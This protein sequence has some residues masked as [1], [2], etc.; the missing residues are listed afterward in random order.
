MRIIAYCHR[1][2]ENCRRKKQLGILTVSE[3]M[4]AENTIARIIQ[5]ESFSQDLDCLRRNQSLKKN[6]KLVTL[7][8]FLDKK[9]LIRVGGRLRH[10][11]PEPTKHS[12][13]LP[14]KHPVT[15]LIFKEHHIK[16]HHCGI[17]QLLTAVR[18]KYW[19][20]SGRNEARKIIRSCLN[21]FRLRPTNASVKMGDLPKERVT[22]YLRPLVV[23]ITRDHCLLERA[24]ASSYIQGLHCFVYL[25]Q[26]KG[27]TLRAGHEPDHRSIYR[28][29]IG[30]RGICSRLF[31][32][33]GT[34]FVGAAR[35]LEELYEFLKASE[36]EKQQGVQ[37]YLTKQKIEWSFIPPIAPNFGGLWES[38]VKSVKRHFYAVTKGL[39]LT[40]EECYTLL[41]EVEA[42]VNSRPLTPCSDNPQDLTVLTPAHFLVGDFLFQ[43]AQK[44]YLDTPDNY[45][46]RWQHIQKVRQD[47]W[48]RWQKEYLVEQQRR[49]KWVNGNT[50]LQKGVLVL[51]KDDHL[52]PLQ[53]AIGRIVDIH[54]GEDGV[55]RVVIVRMAQGLFKRSARSTCPL[56]I[57]ND[58]TTMTD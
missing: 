10:N 33:N 4:K 34:N 24:G 38:A 13:I 17:E 31:S 19:V 46:S 54:P 28:R 57:S 8:P 6:S 52:P 27:D 42:I 49:Y 45:L 29:F 15:G 1:F 2:I 43:P 22:R 40:F 58:I 16:L 48:R 36:E 50:D 5:L 25:F 14:S 12:I 56:P 3:I 47:F 53:W 41:V 51:L 20:L 11:L 37:T 44:S 26:Y 21:C 18:Q 23:W 35:E 39:I 32:D 30:R 55:T 7:D 9:G